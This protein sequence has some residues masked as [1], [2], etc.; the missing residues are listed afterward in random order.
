MLSAYANRVLGQ[1][2]LS[3]LV[4]PGGVPTAPEISPEQRAVIGKLIRLNG[5]VDADYAVGDNVLGAQLTTFDFVRMI[6]EI[7]KRA[8]GYLRE[9]PSNTSAVH[10][11]IQKANE[12]MIA[13]GSLTVESGQ[14]LPGAM[15]SEADKANLLK[16]ASHAVIYRIIRL[17]FGMHVDLL[18]HDNLELPDKWRFASHYNLMGRMLYKTQ[19][20]AHDIGNLPEII[21]GAVA[22]MRGG[23]G[24]FIIPS[25][26][27]VV[28]TMNVF[29]AD[30]PAMEFPVSTLTN[31]ND[32]LTTHNVGGNT[33]FRVY[34]DQD[35]LQPNVKRILQL[36]TV[37]GNGASEIVICIPRAD[38]D[39][40]HIQASLTQTFSI[41]MT[42]LKKRY[43]QAIRVALNKDDDA[44]VTVQE[45]ITGGIFTNEDVYNYARLLN[46]TA[47]APVS[48]KTLVDE[49]YA[50]SFGMSLDKLVVAP[51]IL[52]PGGVAVA[53][54][55]QV[56]AYDMVYISEPVDVTTITAGAELTKKNGYESTAFVSATI[57]AAL[58][59]RVSRFQN[60]AVSSWK[61]TVDSENSINYAVI[62]R[63]LIS[64][65]AGDGS[66]TEHTIA[67]VMVKLKNGNDFVAVP[68]A[69]Y[70]DILNCDSNTSI[71]GLTPGANVTAIGAPNA[72]LVR[73]AD[74][75]TL[76]KR[77][78]SFG[79]TSV[80]A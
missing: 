33:I 73:A 9:I 4:A 62:P 79:P 57:F 12:Y 59:G 6:D 60:A 70:S 56:V 47:N 19:M 46:V 76:T 25:T 51:D 26:R 5:F 32:R 24:A 68:R 48:L 34:V 16:F 37:N 3:D 69:F 75:G 54:A 18:S 52:L 61:T 53:V 31:Q 55:T 13:Q 58:T 50:D 63:T 22:V 72:L 44:N 66:V 43:V 2:G 78:G 45:A 36:G 28:A 71:V 10:Y 8:R 23:G 38:E 14:Y 27:G 7:G 35:I 67:S 29:F 39:K 80:R 1:G 41:S 49:I 15:P 17:I 77:Y 74:V 11:G 21:N 20:G 30:Y 64:N 65:K 42:E 40:P